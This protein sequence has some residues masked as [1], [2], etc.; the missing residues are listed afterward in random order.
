MLK[1]DG[2]RCA[3]PILRARVWS[4][5]V[6]KRHCERSEAIH[7]FLFLATM[8]CFVASA[9][10]NDASV[11]RRM[12]RA[13]AKPITS[14]RVPAASRQKSPRDPKHRL[15]LKLV[16]MFRP[17]PQ[18]PLREIDGDEETAPGDEGDDS[19]LWR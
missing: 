4:Q 8:D 18:P 15:A 12:G 1:R 5:H 17:Y 19:R 9:P 10:R 2:Y 3:P 16:D 6:S 13:L 14:P 7:L 11:T